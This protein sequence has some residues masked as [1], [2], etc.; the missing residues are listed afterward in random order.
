MLERGWRAIVALASDYVF[1][2]IVETNGDYIARPGQA[3]NDNWHPAA[4][5]NC[6]YAAKNAECRV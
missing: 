1:E 5:M 3:A 6:I 4:E 2:W